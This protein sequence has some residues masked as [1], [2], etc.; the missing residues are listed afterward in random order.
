MFTL[1]DYYK[2]IE[3]DRNDH[4]KLFKL[5]PEE[6][7]HKSYTEDTWSPELIFRHLISVLN[8]F[9]NL[10]P[11]SEFEETKLGFEYGTL[12]DNTVSGW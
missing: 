12:P 9:K 3:E 5:V 2:I 8:W 11:T 10:I 6:V 1:A 7:F 4:L